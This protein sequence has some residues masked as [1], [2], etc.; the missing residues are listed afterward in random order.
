V[1]KPSNATAALLEND[2][3][4]GTA[5]SVRLTL[6]SAATGQYIISLL[7]WDDQGQQSPL[8]SELSVFVSQ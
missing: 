8:S 1:K 2:G 5:S 4:R 3:Q 7:V 6:D